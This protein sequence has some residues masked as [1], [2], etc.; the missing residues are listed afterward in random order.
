MVI[1]LL[2]FVVCA[3]FS[4]YGG[5]QAAEAKQ[6]SEEEAREEELRQQGM[7]RSTLAE[8]REKRG[9]AAARKAAEPAVLGPVLPPSASGGTGSSDGDGG[10]ARA[11]EAVGEGVASTKVEKVIAEVAR[12]TTETIMT[13][14]PRT[15][16]EF[17]R[18]LS[19]LGKKGGADGGSGG[20][21]GGQRKLVRWLLGLPV[22]ELPKLLGSILTAD[23]LLSILRPLAAVCETGAK[24]ITSHHPRTTTKNSPRVRCMVIALLSAAFACD[25][26]LPGGSATQ[27][28]EAG[29]AGAALE[30]EGVESAG[31]AAGGHGAPVAALAPAAVL[32]TLAAIAATP[33][34]DMT[35]AFLST[36]EKAVAAAVFESLGAVLTPATGKHLGAT[37]KLY[38]L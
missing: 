29:L 9:L 26:D 11:G 21:K 13:A 2:L 20:D 6:Q 37:R 22:S 27:A 31:A 16:F 33:R 7:R 32:D 23:V 38:K 15:G 36:K 25:T 4:S 8:A 28:A 10:V 5:C 1:E 14:V 19:A 3:L 24:N 30:L 34:F 18:S 17:E 35:V 12:L